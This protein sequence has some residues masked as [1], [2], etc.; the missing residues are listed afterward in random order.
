MSVNLQPLKNV[1]SGA[2]EQLKKFDFHPGGSVTDDDILY[3]GKNGALKFAYD[4]T[5][6]TVFY[7][8][9]VEKLKNGGKK[10]LACLVSENSDAKEI[11]YVVEELS[12]S[13]NTK[14]GKK[15]IKKI[16]SGKTPETV[17]KNAV[18]NGASYDPNTLASRLCL[19]FPELRPLYK[20]NIAIYGEFL[21]EDFFVNHGAPVIIAAIKENKPQTMKKL[22]QVLNEVYEDGTNDV[23]GIIAVT[24]LGELNNDQI[25]LARCIDYMS[26]TM[27]S[28]VIEVNRFLA[29]S[30]GKKAKEKLQNPPPY[31]PKK[32]KRGGFM[33]NALDSGT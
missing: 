27:T 23:Q 8:D 33:S 15:E 1:L 31:K 4:D 9:D 2:E 32:E 30:A 29:T 7:S 13:L 25:L 24:I 22:F 16:P 17:S 18:K 3:S 20:E 19:V 26:E 10:I 6:M 12:E 28:P 21:A 5:R 11:A 14:F